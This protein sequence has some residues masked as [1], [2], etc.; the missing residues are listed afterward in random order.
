MSASA[1]TLAAVEVFRELGW[2]EAT[3]EDVPTL[4]LGDPEQRRIALAGLRSGEFGGFGSVG[5]NHYGW[6]SYV[7]VDTTRLGLYAIR[8]GVDARRAAKLMRFE[9]SPVLGEVLA[10][11]GPAYVT[12]FIELTF[13]GEQWGATQMVV[14]LLDRLGLDVPANTTYLSGWAELAGRTLQVTAGQVQV[15]RDDD[16][17]VPLGGLVREHVRAAVGAGVP[18]TGPLPRVVA[19]LVVRGVLTREEAVGLALEGLD[20]AQRPGDRKAWA[21]TLVGPLGLGQAEMV[22]HAD[23]LVA[24][25]SQG[26]APVVEAF[27]PALV[28][29][30]DED[31]LLDVLTLGLMVRTKKTRLALLAAAATRSAPAPDR[32]ADLVATLVELRS[33]TDRALS[34]SAGAVLDAWVPGDQAVVDAEGAGAGADEGV[35]FA[36]PPV[37]PL[38]E[39]PRFSPGEVSTA[40]L[41]DLAAELTS[42]PEDVLDLAAERFLQV[43]VALGHR[44][45]DDVRVALRGLRPTWSPGI[46]AAADWLSGNHIRML[47]RGNTVSAPPW[48]RDAAVFQRLGTI[49][50]LLSTPSWEDL[51]VDLADLVERLDAHASAGAA[52]AEADLLL[53]LLRL[54]VTSATPALRT[55]LESLDLPVVLQSGEPLPVHLGRLVLDALDHPL[56]EPTGTRIPE[57]SGLVLPG[58]IGQFPPRI[59]RRE[60]YA[61]PDHTTVPA[62]Q[63]AGARWL[64]PSPRADAGLLAL[65]FVRRAHP[66]T[67]ATAVNL[68]GMLRSPHARAEADLHTALAQAW[69]R[70]LLRPGVADGS[71]LDWV[72]TPS[73]LAAFSSACLGLAEEGLAPVVWSA[74]DPLVV[75]SLEKPRLL[76]GTAE[77][78]EAIETLLPTVTGA[79]ADSSAPASALDLPGV[80]ELASRGGSSRATVAAR[81][82]VALLPEPSPAEGT[83]ERE[84]PTLPPFAERWPEGP[85]A[86]PTVDDGARLAAGVVPG[87]GRGKFLALDITPPGSATTY[88]VVKRWF[89]D[90]RA[91]GQ[92]QA[93]VLDPAPGQSSTTWLHWDAAA[94]ALVASDVRDRYGRS[95]GPLSRSGPRP[96]LTTSMVAVVLASMCHDSTEDYYLRDILTGSLFGSG[97]V[98]TAIGALL[99]SPAVSPARMMRFLEQDPLLLPLLWP[100]LTEPVRR[101]A[102]YDKPPAWLNRVLGVALA[103]AATLRE[104]GERG[105]L[106]EAASWPGLADLAART[107]SQAALRK[108]RELT[109]ALVG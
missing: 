78:V 94:G 25:L 5:P 36:W 61:L 50:C 57:D 24:A 44:D 11:R 17:L 81:R 32:V 90:L 101:A 100:L 105:L 33:G 86:V 10:Q 18:A 29:H 75:T 92:C 88:R 103:N 59:R 38:W 91:E 22:E 58:W 47:D 41:T 51:R 89:H 46:S 19:E 109:E 53:A 72:R 71:L 4:P 79:V 12:T 9:N 7:D 67:P 16:Q 48:A 23:A 8:V 95:G 42:R 39:V 62:W 28:L 107:G 2:V 106:G 73:A 13:R 21:E 34:R 98:H 45:L 69:Q 83:G 1:A 96:P 55:R 66:L 40:A 49:P 76:S 6:V 70:G 97:A 63:T 3:D 37:P 20:T 85:G 84:G 35:R 68:I 77:V 82:V 60:W 15:R 104:A 27:G 14:P 54:E 30:G 102:A 74:L 93:D 99:E 108:A 52:V 64:E 56:V 43:A 26:E 31:T 80:R 87:T 65:Q